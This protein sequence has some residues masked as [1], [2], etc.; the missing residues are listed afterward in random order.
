MPK[1]ALT[2]TVNVFPP[3]NCLGNAHRG[4]VFWRSSEWVRAQLDGQRASLLH[5]LKKLQRDLCGMHL[6][7]RRFGTGQPRPAS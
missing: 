4:D 3:G 6:H 1:E 5:R 2:G 7:Q